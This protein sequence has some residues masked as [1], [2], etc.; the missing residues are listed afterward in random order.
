M[1]Y[2]DTQDAGRGTRVLVGGADP[3]LGRQLAGRLRVLGCDVV[4]ARHLL[5]VLSRLMDHRP[6]VVFLDASLDG[7][8]GYRT[9]ALIKSD[10]R[11]QGI[12]VIVVAAHDHVIERA[13]ASLAGA[14]D[15]L[16]GSPAPDLLAGLLPERIGGRSD[17][18]TGAR[19]A[20]AREKWAPKGGSERSPKR[21]W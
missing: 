3:R 18:R 13:R 16:A 12:S 10:P 15:F 11:L 4:V 7:L 17:Q 21:A 1:E 20:R 2:G 14:D 19:Q 9:C 6:E 5:A 8:D